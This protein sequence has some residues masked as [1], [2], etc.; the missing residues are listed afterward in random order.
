MKQFHVVVNFA[1]TLG[2]QHSSVRLG[3]LPYY[4]GG[5]M[6]IFGADLRQDSVREEVHLQIVK[7]P[8]WVVVTIFIETFVLSG[9]CECC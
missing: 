8:H 1:F 6:C 2:Y 4:L 5:Q 3:Q 7:F 9:N